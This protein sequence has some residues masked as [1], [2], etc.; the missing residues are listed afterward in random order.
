MREECVRCLQYDGNADCFPQIV[1]HFL[2]SKR[3][4][5]KYLGFSPRFMVNKFYIIN[6]K[7]NFLRMEI[8]LRLF[9]FCSHSERKRGGGR[10]FIFLKLQRFLFKSTTSR[11]LGQFQINKVALNWIFV[12]KSL[13]KRQNGKTLS[14]SSTHCRRGGVVINC[15]SIDHSSCFGQQIY[16]F[17][18]CICICA[19]YFS[20][21]S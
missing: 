6:R 15:F 2:Q 13:A 4:P 9:H 17:V 11:V 8:F 19:K 12:R 20:N 3:I 16:F 5:P 14:K 10:C 7:S 1:E 21:Q 18:F